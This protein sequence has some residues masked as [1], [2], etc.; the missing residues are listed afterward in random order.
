M[1][2]H[3]DYRLIACAVFALIMTACSRNPLPGTPEATAA[4]E[5]LM[6][7]MSDTL[8]HS[9]AFTFETTERIEVIAP[10]GEKRAL[11]FTRKAAVQRPNALFFELH[12]EDQKAFDI[13]ACYHDRTLLLS[14]KLEGRWA[15]TTVPGTLDEMLDDVIRRFGL[16]VPIGDV[17]S[18]SPY[19]AIVGS[20]ARGGLVAWETIDQVPCA[21][22][23]YADAFVEVRLWLPQSGPPLPHRLE[24]AYKQAPVPLV[25]QLNFTNWELNRQ[26]TDPTFACQPPAGREPVEFRDLV[27]ALVSRAL[28]QE[29]Q[30]DASA[31]SVGKPVGKPV[32]AQ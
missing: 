13:A 30:A 1:Q 14:D 17:V 6:R 12:G 22:L 10:S 15:E 23:N 29:I 31:N 28:P 11:H 27:S 25:T 16:P 2:P 20:S 7:S 8:A 4:G 32:G 5:R 26:V 19:D 3:T 24:I 21:K 9:K 18:G